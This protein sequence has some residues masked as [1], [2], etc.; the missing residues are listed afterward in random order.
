MGFS[1]GMVG[2]GAICLALNLAHVGVRDLWHVLLA[3]HEV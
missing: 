3:S 2:C 1:R